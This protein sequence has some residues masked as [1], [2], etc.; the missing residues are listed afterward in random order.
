MWISKQNHW[1]KFQF[2]KHKIDDFK[3][4]LEIEKFT[5]KSLVWKVK[6]IDLDF[7]VFGRIIGVTKNKLKHNFPLFIHQ[8]LYLGWVSSYHLTPWFNHQ[9]LFYKELKFYLNYFKMIIKLT[10]IKNTKAIQINE[11][12]FV[13]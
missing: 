5:C 8:C 11:C 7:L 1:N 12:F 13:D 6:Y 9:G 2:N 10:K 3:Y 4:Q